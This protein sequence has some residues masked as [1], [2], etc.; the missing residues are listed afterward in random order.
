MHN[1]FCF[2]SILLFPLANCALFDSKLLDRWI[3]H[4]EDIKK[5][6]FV[7]NLIGNSNSLWTFFSILCRKWARHPFVQPSWQFFIFPQAPKKA[8]RRQQ[9]GEGGSSNVFSMFEQ[10]QIQ[11]YKEVTCSSFTW[12][13]LRL[14]TF[15]HSPKTDDSMCHLTLEVMWG[16][17]PGLD[18]NDTV[19]AEYVL[20]S[21][22]GQ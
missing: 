21:M 20:I 5:M 17:L 4:Q 1:I 6:R 18:Q 15:H 8:K 12:A 10:S 2:I 22:T 11:E 14:R 3:T 9:Q 13:P 19:T 16:G 7:G